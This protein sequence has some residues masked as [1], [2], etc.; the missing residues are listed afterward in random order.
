VKKLSALFDLE[1]KDFAESQRNLDPFFDVSGKVYLTTEQNIAYTFGSWQCLHEVHS[2]VDGLSKLLGNFDIITRLAQTE[3]DQILKGEVTG[4]WSSNRHFSNENRYKKP[5]DV[6][7]ICGPWY[8]H[9]YFVTF[10]LC[11]DCKTILDRL[12]DKYVIDPIVHENDKNIKK[13]PYK[14][15]GI[16]VPNP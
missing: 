11:P 12:T 16:E 1:F 2:C 15:K 8:M 14:L 13:N 3:I 5:L 4:K 7:C 10:I 9:G 6:L